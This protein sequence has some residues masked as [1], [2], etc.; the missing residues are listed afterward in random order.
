MAELDKVRAAMSPHQDA[1][2]SVS[3]HVRSVV[4]DRH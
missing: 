4:L 3:A 1:L 2:S